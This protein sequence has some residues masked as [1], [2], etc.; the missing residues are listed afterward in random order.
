MMKRRYQ[1]FIK[2]LLNELGPPNHSLGKIETA[3]CT[4][5][6]KM[7]LRDHASE[8]WLKIL[9]DQEFLKDHSPP[10]LQPKP[11]S[12]D[13]LNISGKAERNVSL[14]FASPRFLF[15]T[16]ATWTQR[17]CLHGNSSSLILHMAENHETSQDLREINTTLFEIT[18]QN[19][20]NCEHGMVRPSLWGYP[21][22]CSMFPL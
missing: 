2:R 22:N 5:L 18:S 21:L 1:L 20:E 9:K 8:I 11:V 19:L 13:P 7:R 15:E 17:K 14:H 12:A 3:R 4:K 16:Y 10:L 6:Q